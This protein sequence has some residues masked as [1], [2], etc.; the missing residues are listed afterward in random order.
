MLTKLKYFH[1]LCPL[2][3]SHHLMD[4]LTSCAFE[5]LFEETKV[6]K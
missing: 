5:D 2:A 3:C 1:K 6:E 4:A